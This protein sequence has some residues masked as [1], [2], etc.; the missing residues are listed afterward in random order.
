MKHKPAINLQKSIF[1]TFSAGFTL[2]EILVAV[3]MVATLTGG[4]LLTLNPQKQIDKTRD[5]VKA[6]DLRQ[7]KNALDA[8]YEDNKC[9]PQSVPFG[10]DWT[11]NGTVYMKKVPQD[12]SCNNGQGSCYLYK[13]P[14]D[15]CPQWNILFSRI[16]KA[17]SQTT[18]CA[19]SSLS[20]CAPK[21]YTDYSWACTLSGAVD[22][23]NLV[24]TTDM[25]GGSLALLPTPTPAGPGGPTPT[26]TPPGGGQGAPTSTPTPTASPND[27]TYSI[28]NPSGTN[29]DVYQAT[30]QPLYQ[31][32][33]NG[34]AMN[35][36]V[37]STQGTISS[38]SVVLYSDHEAKQFNLSVDPQ[39][40]SSWNGAWQVTDTYNTRY[41]YDITATDS[42]GNTKTA[43]LRIRN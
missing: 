10:S 31:Y 35:V 11:H 29:P 7:I 17:S 6:E 40:N 23:D 33:G 19:L 27:V 20:N 5:S 28:G 18:S 16:S 42:V 1:S 4:L 15:N 43:Q 14:E 26:P 36:L 37:D 8:Y 3:A 22:C 9:F 25:S 34:Q 39:N 13:V 21:G 30:I 24:S 2:V 41:G 38:V 32:S 12:S